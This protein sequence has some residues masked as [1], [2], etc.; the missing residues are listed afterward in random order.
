EIGQYL[1][2]NG[3]KHTRHGRGE[4]LARTAQL[5]S[6]QAVVGWFQG[7]MEF[8]P[9]ALG[10][11]SIIADARNKDNWQRVNLKIKYRES[12]RPF[13]PSV[14]EDRAGEY[15]AIDVPAP[16]M[17]V[18]AQVHEHIRRDPQQAIPAVTHVDGSARLQT[19]SRAQNPLYYDLIAAFEE[20]TGCAVIIN[21]SFNVRG[22]PIV[23]TPGD[24]YRC[25]MRTEMDY[26]VLGSFVLDKREM[27]PLTEDRDW[28]EI[29]QLD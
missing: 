19:V 22:E 20:L 5:I 16:Y 6:G 4:L 8:G 27:A 1:T 13:A 12:F 28:R 23:C 9:R 21:T 3:I 26:L 24:A 11:R 17:L 18:T 15:F 2:A 7:R 25:F 14:L 10:N 29:Y